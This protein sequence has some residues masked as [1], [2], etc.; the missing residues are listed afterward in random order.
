MEQQGL[1]SR[2][3]M[4]SGM[5]KKMFRVLDF[6]CRRSWGFPLTAVMVACLTISAWGK[7]LDLTEMSIEELMGLEV[8]SP[9]RKVQ[10]LSDTATA[11]HVITQEDIRRSGASSIPEALRLAPGLHVAYI[12]ANTW[13][14]SARGFSREFANKLLVLVDGRTV[15]TPFFSGVYWD[16]VGTVL[17]DVDRIEVIL[18]PGAAMWGANAVNG[19]INIITKQADQTQGTLVSVGVG[20]E[21]RTTTT[22]RHGGRL[23]ENV[24]YR[25]YGKYLARGDSY[26][27]GLKG[28]DADTYR[29]GFRIDSIPDDVDHFTFQ[30]EAFSMQKTLVTGF[31]LIP[32]SS[33]E[34]KEDTVSVKG[35]NILAR[36][37]HMYTG[38]STH[39]VT[40][41]YDFFDRDTPLATE[42]RN[43]FD[44]DFQLNTQRDRHN[45]TLGGGYRVTEDRVDETEVLS[46]VPSSQRDHLFSAFL[47]D[48]VEVVDDTLHVIAGSKFEHNDYTG[49]EIQPNIRAILTPNDRQSI[50]AAVSRAV[51]TPSR[52]ASG[53]LATALLPAELSAPGDLPSV[54]TQMGNTRVDSEELMAYEMGYRHV[55]RS[56]FRYDIALFWN[57]YDHLLSSMTLPPREELSPIPRRVIPGVLENST[58]ATS[59][60]GEMVATVEVREWWTC[61]VT[62]SY[63]DIDFRESRAGSN[64]NNTY[65]GVYV[66]HQ[67]SLFS[68]M[69]LPFNCQLDSFLRYVDGDAS[70]RVDDYVT[71]DLRLGWRP[72]EKVELSI[73]GQNLI[74]DHHLEFLSDLY[75]SRTREVERGVYAKA[76]VMF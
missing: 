27:D 73:V 47:Q 28:D 29:G 35:G 60:G 59:Y 20:T 58:E 1:L 53:M 71:L 51:R 74:E 56:G 57:E 8:F 64:A 50:W 55:V 11:V 75:P 44:I 2:K 26:T 9:G 49:F 16:Q 69:N 67:A 38:G 63:V 65:N 6:P 10:L 3:W 24:F 18:G 39:R 61:R 21:L 62:Y 76:I 68:T 54:Q 48:E 52:S 72:T 40:S 17:P 14:I 4:G 36:W 70:G 34:P 15:Y 45:I 37:E 7:S 19:V 41:Y 33:P 13:A 31:P 22:V 66:K 46:V 32:L 43:T 12:D 5:E 42:R 25:A 30:G 23:A